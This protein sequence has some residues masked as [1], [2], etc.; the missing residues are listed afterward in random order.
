MQRTARLAMERGSATTAKVGGREVTVF[1]GCDYLGLSCHP[2]VTAAATRS[3]TSIGISASASRE[4]TGN[5][6]PHE[7]LEETITSFLGVESAQ[8]TPEG[9][10]A[11][12]AA[13]SA[14]SRAQI[15]LV[16]EGAHASVL[17]A[18]DSSGAEVIRYAH[19]D[20]AD[21]VTRIAANRGKR[22]AV[23]T[24]GYFAED[25][26]PAPIEPILR[27]LP[28]S[29][30]LIIDECHAFGVI[31]PR[32]RGTLD[33]LGFRDPRVVITSTL[34]KGIGCYGGFVAGARGF[35]ERARESTAAYCTTPV[36]PAL[37]DAART[38]IGL[39][40]D[41]RSLLKRLRTSGERLRAALKRQGIATSPRPLPVFA[42]S[43]ES[44]ERMRSLHERLL[45][46]GILFPLIRY[47]GVRSGHY[48]RVAASAAHTDKQLDSLDRALESAMSGARPVVES[49]HVA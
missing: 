32:G 11:N 22:I 44:R 4:T 9:M 18:A 46:D 16:D 7:R 26:E 8:L 37:A 49:T 13:A 5:T 27:T 20:A 43:F 36:P 21:A 29:G 39:V 41:D 25:G 17:A 1:G 40:D 23:M 48:F 14:A 33:L 30:T 2:E 47:P 12:L 28:E 38:A 31:G 6:P 42:F 35:I 34:A 3:L 45:D 15:L 19:L 10:T 24:D